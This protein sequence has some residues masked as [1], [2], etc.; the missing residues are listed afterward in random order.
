MERF[1]K[2]LSKY[3]LCCCV[4]GLFALLVWGQTVRYVLW[5]DGI[6]ANN[7][8]LTIGANRCNPES[9]LE[10]GEAGDSFDGLMD[11]VMMFNRALA[12]DEV[13]Q[14]Y[15]LAAAP[16]ATAIRVSA[17]ANAGASPAGQP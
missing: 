9:S 12:A 8:D 3:W 15:G 11:V 10:P 1:E 13:R 6:L 5:R 17:R 16:S 2:Y 7:C 4:I 14:L